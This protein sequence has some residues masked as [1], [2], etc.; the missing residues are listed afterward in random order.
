MVSELLA[1]A[2]VVA[3]SGLRQFD[4]PRL[5]LMSFMVQW[6]GLTSAAVLCAVRHRFERCGAK[7]NIALTYS[8][9]LI[10]TLLVAICGQYLI[11]GRAWSQ[12]DW[13]RVAESLL[14]AAI[15]V[16]IALRYFYLQQ[17]L[18]NQ[19]QA[20]LQSRIQA[21]QSRIRPHFLFNSM[22]SI[23]SLIEVDPETAERVVEDLSELFRASLAEPTLIPLER[24]LQLGR[25]YLDIEQLR[26][27][28]R[29]QLDW[30]VED[31][32]SSA[33]IPSLLLQPLLEN[34]IYHGIQRSVEGGCIGFSVTLNGAAI[35]I[36]VRN[37]LAQTAASEE[38]NGMALDNIRHRLQAHYGERG[39]LQSGIYGDEFVVQV[40]L[41]VQEAK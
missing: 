21:L 38:G 22:N 19:R 39:R 12:L 37:P 9:V 20:E 8:T 18:Q 4:W 41:P 10:I 36:V 30:R 11:F 26:I 16:G 29:L 33:T 28:D 34:A 31:F 24:E 40:T 27:G 2:L 3:E 17:Q 23:A 1:L 15:F 14:V 5:A 6:V 35:D 25:R 7:L 13:W 32:P